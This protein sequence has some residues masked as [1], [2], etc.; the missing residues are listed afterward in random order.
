MRKQ[1]VIISLVVIFVSLNS[2]GYT[3]ELEKGF[4]VQPDKLTSLQEV[5]VLRVIDGD[6]LE[7]TTGQ[8]VRLIGIDTPE[9]E[10]SSQPADYYATQ[11]TAFTRENLAGETIY[12]EY[13]VEKRDHYNRLLA[14]VFKQNGILFN[15]QLLQEGY[16]TLLTIPPNVKYVDTFQQLVKDARKN[17]RGLWAKD[18]V[19]TNSDLPVI[20]WQDATN[21]LGEEVIVQ[22]KIVNTY[23]SRGPIF[24]NFA[25]DYRA[26]L[27]AVIFVTDQNNFSVTPA[28]YFLDRKVMIK[29]RI[30]EYEGAPEII[31]TEPR[32]I[33]VID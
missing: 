32:Q 30:K 22:G 12:L 13:G 33:Q 31:I 5:E 24:L 25:S 4:Q 8:K 21:H 27:T 6:T 14:Y 3:L 17:K 16:A 1:L 29:G 2:L 11:A 10:S 9:T 19:A 18:L 23:N 7:L 20:N 15:A 28:D 26:H